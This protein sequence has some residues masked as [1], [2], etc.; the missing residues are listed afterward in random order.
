[1][2]KL[3]QVRHRHTQPA[4][5]FRALRQVQRRRFRGRTYAALPHSLED[6]FHVVAGFRPAPLDGSLHDFQRLLRQQLH[7]ANVVLDAPPRTVLFFQS[8]T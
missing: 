5:R 8:G 3:P 4:D 7:H 6:G 1:L 2:V